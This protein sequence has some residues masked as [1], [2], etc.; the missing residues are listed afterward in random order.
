MRGKTLRGC[1]DGVNSDMLPSSLSDDVDCREG[2]FVQTQGS[3]VTPD[4][5]LRVNHILRTLQLLIQLGLNQF[6]SRGQRFG[7]SLGL[8]QDFILSLTNGIAGKVFDG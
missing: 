8:V 6:L 1:T 2:S 5:S 4:P 7:Y 3:V